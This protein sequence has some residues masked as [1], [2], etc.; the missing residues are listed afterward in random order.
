M[1]GRSLDDSDSDDSDDDEDRD[2]RLQRFLHKNCGFYNTKT[3]RHFP[4]TCP[5]GGQRSE[6]RLRFFSGVFLKRA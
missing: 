2:P 6:V 4:M 1:G 3:S 5:S